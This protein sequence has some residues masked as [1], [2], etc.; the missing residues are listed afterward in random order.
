VVF[1]CSSSPPVVFP[2]SSP[3][4]AAADPAMATKGKLGAVAAVEAPAEHLLLR[5]RYG[6][7][8]S[9]RP[10]PARGGALPPRGGGGLLRSARA[11]SSFSLAR[12]L[13]A[14][15]FQSEVSAL[16]RSVADH[17]SASAPWRRPRSRSRRAWTAAH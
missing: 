9:G 10:A 11:S 13:A 14:A 5:C 2:C 12:H 16:N 15:S 8:V 6:G 4:L 3:P 1:P 7:Y 17:S